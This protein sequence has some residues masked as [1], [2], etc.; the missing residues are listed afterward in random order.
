MS[1]YLY[2]FKLFDLCYLIDELIDQFNELTS[3]CWTLDDSR[4]ASYEINLACQSVSL[5]LKI[6]SLVFS[7]IVSDDS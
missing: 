4:T 2:R 6:G 5:F 3:G 7:G 1:Q